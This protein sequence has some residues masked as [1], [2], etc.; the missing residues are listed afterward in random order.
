MKTLQSYKSSKGFTLIELL[1][2]IGLIG[3]LAGVV[4][5]V[6][7]PVQQFARGRDAG[8]K[9]TVGQLG[10]A[11]QAYYVSQTSVWPTADASWI[12]TLTTAGELKSVPA[13][14]TY[15]ISGTAACTTNVQNTFCYNKGTANDAAVWVRLE[16]GAEKEKCKSV[17]ATDGTNAGTTAY[18]LFST[19]DARAGTACMAGEPTAAHIDAGGFVYK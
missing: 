6:I 7:D 4:L 16:S 19:K 2:V 12:T 9:S 13:T 5:V 15:S 10:K 17:V 11:I 18:F 14:T 8:R 3:V 1:V